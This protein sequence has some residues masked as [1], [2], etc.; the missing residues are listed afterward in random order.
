[1]LFNKFSTELA[2]IIKAGEIEFFSIYIVPVLTP[3]GTILVTDTGLSPLSR[4]REI[5]WR[6]GHKGKPVLT[7]LGSTHHTKLESYKLYDFTFEIDALDGVKHLTL[8]ID[9]K[10]GRE[11]LFL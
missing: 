5:V 3:H 1:M 11:V 10:S 8:A 6:F 4:V 2:K 7:I 9:F